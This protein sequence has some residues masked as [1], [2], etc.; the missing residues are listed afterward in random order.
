M[1]AEG[2]KVSFVE[3]QIRAITHAP[4]RYVPILEKIMRREIFHST[5]DWQTSAQFNSGA[6]KAKRMFLKAPTFYIAE[7]EMDEAVCRRFF[8]EGAL[9][10]AKSDGDANAI[11]AAETALAEALAE[12]ERAISRFN[13]IS[14]LDLAV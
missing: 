1:R 2:N 13:R 5:L 7:H 12:Q 9:A 10:R 3:E 4:E 8:A 6:R 14:G 11:S